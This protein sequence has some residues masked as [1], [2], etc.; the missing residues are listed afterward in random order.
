M[1]E[2]SELS[3]K[4]FK[5][6]MIKMLREQSHLTQMKK[7]KSFSQEIEI[8]ILFNEIEDKKDKME[9][10]ETKNIVTENIITEKKNS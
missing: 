5:A 3:D 4:D 10:L 1:T 7:K 9:M 2:M 8:E 6:A